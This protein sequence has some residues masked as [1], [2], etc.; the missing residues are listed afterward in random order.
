M[1]RK[2]E[3]AKVMYPSNP[4]DTFSR[5][6]KLPV[7]AK[8]ST[9]RSKTL[10]EIGMRAAFIIKLLDRVRVSHQKLSIFISQSKH[11]KTTIL[12]YFA[13]DLARASSFL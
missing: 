5:L 12:T 6:K 7:F 11:V 4:F 8:A 10:R 9:D 2:R 1:Y 3:G 13:R